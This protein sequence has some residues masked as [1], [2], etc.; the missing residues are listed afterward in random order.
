[1]LFQPTH[2]QATLKT[3]FPTL[4]DCV[5]HEALLVAVTDQPLSLVSRAEAWL[6]E[7]DQH[8]V[9]PAFV[10]EV[11]T[12]RQPYTAYTVGAVRGAELPST[13][14][15]TYKVDFH[16]ASPGASGA[17]GSSGGTGGPPV[18]SG[19]SGGVAPATALSS[20]QS[21]TSAG[22][23]SPHTIHRFTS[24]LRS[25][26]Y[27]AVQEHG[28]LLVKRF[29]SDSLDAAIQSKKPLKRFKEKNPTVGI[30][31]FV[32][33]GTPTKDEFL[34]AHIIV[35]RALVSRLLRDVVI[36][37][38]TALPQDASTKVRSLSAAE[39]LNLLTSRRPLADILKAFLTERNPGDA[40]K[41]TAYVNGLSHK[42]V[43]DEL[44]SRKV[45]VPYLP[46]VPR[47][48]TLDAYVTSSKIIGKKS[49]GTDLEALCLESSALDAASIGMRPSEATWE[50][51][52]PHAKHY[53]LM[54]IANR[55]KLE[56][57]GAM[58]MC[59]W[60]I[61][62]WSPCGVMA[63]A[64]DVLREEFERADLLPPPSVKHPDLQVLAAVLGDLIALL[65]DVEVRHQRGAARP[66]ELDSFGQAFEAAMYLSMLKQDERAFII[67]EALDEEDREMLEDGELRLTSDVV[68]MDACLAS[69]V[70][71]AFHYGLVDSCEPF[72]VD[73]AEAVAANL[74]I[75]LAQVYAGVETSTSLLVL[76][77]M[78][79]SYLKKEKDD[80][81]GVGD[82]YD[83]SGDDDG[84]DDSGDSGDDG[85]SKRCSQPN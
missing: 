54:P 28:A 17:A 13:A 10:T 80:G 83:D 7:L 78:V 11:T 6:N 24:P 21:G 52:T 58:A 23:V 79:P 61:N 29:N 22:G 56:Y 38:G 63:A 33:H 68:R 34:E 47:C 53:S 66:P 30:S 76:G 65:V 3:T 12:R 84:D 39:I 67:M 74:N 18:A 16:P 27:K 25:S 55:L 70:M 32:V 73:L 14:S 75:D 42:Q 43:A 9:L 60:P 49:D 59:H 2:S 4:P 57:F 41:I 51:E 44:A 40:A 46:Y 69:L 8:G 35:L 77:E 72:A 71:T 1:M 50:H 37:Q 36:S 81:V 20:G 85:D 19:P 62:A 26:D 31:I 15:G 5:L 48:Y 45:G 82:D 64:A